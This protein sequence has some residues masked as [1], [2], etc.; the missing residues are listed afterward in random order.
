MGQ[1]GY[2]PFESDGGLDAAF[3]LLNHLIKE[4]ERLACGPH[5]RG[6]SLIWDEQQLA[7]NVELLCLVAE[8]VYRP[9]MFVPVRGM[10]LPDPEAIANWRDQFLARWRKLGKRQIEGTPEEVERF[11]LSAAIPYLRLADLSRRQIEQSEVTHREAQLEVVEARKR[12]EAEERGNANP[13][14]GTDRGSE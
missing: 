9:A 3:S 1:W 14:D 6:S 7:A 10:P 13:N 4:V 8:A 2:Q 11:G 5:P 12:E